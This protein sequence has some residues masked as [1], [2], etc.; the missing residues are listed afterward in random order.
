MYMSVAFVTETTTVME[1]DL[2]CT[3]YTW[4]HTMTQQRASV[5]C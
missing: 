3:F 2:S 5:I 1:P 4:N